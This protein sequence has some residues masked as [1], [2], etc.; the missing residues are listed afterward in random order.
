MYEFTQPIIVDGAKATPRLGLTATPL[1]DAI[2]A[3]VA[4]F[5]GR[6]PA[7]R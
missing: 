4:W 1:D 3:T 5:R 7:T 6:D 2:R